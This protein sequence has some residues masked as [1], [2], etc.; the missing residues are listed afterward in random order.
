MAISWEARAA[1]ILFVT[2]R[3]D[4]DRVV[5]G[6]YLFQKWFI[7]LYVHLNS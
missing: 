6:A 4:D 2:G 1:G 5:E 3:V 7:S